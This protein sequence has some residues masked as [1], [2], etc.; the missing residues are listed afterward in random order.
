MPHRSFWFISV[1]C[2]VFVFV[3]LVKRLEIIFFFFLGFYYFFFH[4]QDFNHPSLK[5]GRIRRHICIFKGKTKTSRV[6]INQAFKLESLR[7]SMT[8]C[9]KRNQR[10]MED[11]RFPPARSRPSGANRELWN[12]PS[13]L[14]AYLLVKESLALN[15][16][17]HGPVHASLAYLLAN[18]KSSIFNCQ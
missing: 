3:D 15:R 4:E 13:L 7:W 9:K 1:C 14:C 18:K 6:V 17:L 16:P 5:T 10:W 8:A 2:Q 12:L 11:M